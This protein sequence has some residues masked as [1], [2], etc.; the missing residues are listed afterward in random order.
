[1]RHQQSNVPLGM[2]CGE[3]DLLPVDHHDQEH[4]EAKERES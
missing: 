4:D 1:M 2:R 3:W